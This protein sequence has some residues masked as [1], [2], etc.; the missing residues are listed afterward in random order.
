MNIAATALQGINQADVQMGNAAIAIASAGTAP[1]DQPNAD[2]VDLSSAVV[3][4]AASKNQYSAQLATLK[5]NDE[6]Q[7]SL[8]DVMA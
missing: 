3:A 6:T 5:A 7:K 1:T 4:L 2:T 8:L